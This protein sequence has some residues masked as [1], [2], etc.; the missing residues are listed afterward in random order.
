MAKRKKAFHTDTLI[1]AVADE[2]CVAHTVIDT[3][4]AVNLARGVL[5]ARGTRFHFYQIIVSKAFKDI[6]AIWR[7]NAISFL[8]NNMSVKA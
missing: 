5:V 8:K 4:L 7:V 2:L 6:Y 1:S 3:K